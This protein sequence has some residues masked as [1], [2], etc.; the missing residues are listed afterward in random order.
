MPSSLI[1]RTAT[2]DDI[3]LIASMHA[4]SWASA[5]RGI[6][7]DTY[8]D[9]DVDADR[10]TLWQ[11]QTNELKS[12]ARCVFIAEWNGV[13]AGF[14][15]VVAPD[16]AGGVLVDNL[17]ALPGH[18]GLGIGTALLDEAACWARLQG[19]RALYLSVLEDNKAAI[20]FYASR[21]W[22]CVAREADDVAGIE[23]FSLRYVLSLE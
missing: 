3:P 10:R 8:L 7:P 20:A 16:A 14:A 13:A 11:S 17:H 15:C 6:L 18:R 12:G 19:A 2:E 22:K 23:L 21:R 1:L 4:R 9:H 5:Y